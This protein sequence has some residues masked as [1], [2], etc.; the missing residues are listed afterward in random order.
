MR[1][2]FAVVF[3][4]SVF[5]FFTDS[6]SWSAEESDYMPLVSDKAGG[7]VDLALIYQGGVKRIPWTAEQFRPYLTWTDPE[8][9][10]EEWLFDGFLFL[11]IQSGKGEMYAKGYGSKPAT[12]EDWLWYLDRVFAPDLAVHALDQA[13]DR[14]IKR[15][16][17]PPRPRKVVLTVPEPIVQT[18]NWGELEGK[19]LDFTNLDDRIAATKWFIDQLLKRWEDG[20]FQHLELAGFYWVAEEMGKSDQQLVQETGNYIRSKQKRFFWIPWWGSPGSRIWKE[21]GFDAVYQQPNYFFPKHEKPETQVLEA[22]DFAKSQDMGLEMEWDG[23]IFTDTENFAP[24]FLNYVDSFEQKGVWN[25]SAV[26][27][28]MSGHGMIEFQKSEVPRVIEL[29]NRYCKILSQRQK[30]QD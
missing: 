20:N 10:K 3:V 22:C 15:L 28:Y 14:T 1:F 2:L 27:H 8:T 26:A 6:R 18:V 4:F 24:R 19:P 5:V 13:L 23:R 25:R 30:R 17:S 9:R 11:E 16:G 7:I 21:L 29:Y 12:K